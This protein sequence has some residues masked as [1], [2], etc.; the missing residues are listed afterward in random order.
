MECHW[1]HESVFFD[2]PGEQ[3]LRLRHAADTLA[4]MPS[5]YW[6]QQ[7]APGHVEIDQAAGR[8]QA[9]GIFVQPAVAHFVE[10]EDP[11]EDQKWVLDF[12]TDFRFC[13]VFRFI[14]LGQRTVPRPLFVGKVRGGGSVRAQD[15]ALP[16][17]SRITPHLGL[18]PV[19]K[20]FQHLTVMHIRRCGH[21]PSRR[22]PAIL[23]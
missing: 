20:I 7:H 1:L 5:S 6:P 13:P 14:R 11:F 4:R 23:R 12:G 10:A 21:H 17:I 19:Q 15:L 3:F 2:R 16:T 22:S 9:I 18:P 8:K